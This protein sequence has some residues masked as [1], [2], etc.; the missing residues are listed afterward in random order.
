MDSL[1]DIL[2]ERGGAEERDRALLA[3][4]RR[5]ATM[6]RGIAAPRLAAHLT[7]QNPVTGRTLVWC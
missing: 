6:R 5:M 4:F 3:S 2:E 1:A 7:K